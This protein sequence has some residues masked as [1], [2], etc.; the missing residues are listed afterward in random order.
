MC[1]GDVIAGR[2]DS[3]GGPFAVDSSALIDMVVGADNAAFK[4]ILLPS[5][6]ISKQ[7]RSRPRRPC[8][9]AAAFGWRALSAPTMVAAMGARL[10]ACLA[11][12]R[13]V[14]A[15]ASCGVQLH[16]REQLPGNRAS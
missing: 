9:E 6:I 11:A 3:C 4:A 8:C 14:A 1:R 7:A 12:A 10:R 15:V 13:A 5:A 2:G 16:Q